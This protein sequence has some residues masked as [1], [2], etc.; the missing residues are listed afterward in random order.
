MKI[1]AEAAFLSVLFL[2]PAKA[3][4]MYADSAVVG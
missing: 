3:S 1:Q 4:E 2:K